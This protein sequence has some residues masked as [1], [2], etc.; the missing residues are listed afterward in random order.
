MELLDECVMWNLV[1][2]RLEIELVSVQY[3]CTVCSEHTIC[4]ELVL[5]VPDG[6][7]R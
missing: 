3:G 2:V 7:P 6:T 5:D 1:S 4:L